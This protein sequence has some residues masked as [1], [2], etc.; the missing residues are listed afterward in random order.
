V[1]DP[2]PIE[3]QEKYFKLATIHRILKQN[4]PK[5]TRIEK[6]ASTA[7]HELLETIVFE[8]LIKLKTKTTEYRT[9]TGYM[10]GKECS[11]YLL[12]QQTLA[13]YAR[14]LDEIES[15]IRELKQSEAKI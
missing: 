10:V 9:I 12:R 14:V 7:L 13:S 4:L 15:R 8:I 11:K 6:D 2:K 1:K 5:E 3:N